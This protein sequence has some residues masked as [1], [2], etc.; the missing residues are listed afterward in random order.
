MG[1]TRL[2]PGEI[3]EIRVGLAELMTEVREVRADVTEIKGHT[4]ATNGRVLKLELWQARTIGAV[5]VL[6]F[7]L[8]ALAV[9]MLVA[10][11]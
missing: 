6:M 11:L 4:S 3:A 5:A 8:S 1:V 7:L 9:P 2:T 10:V